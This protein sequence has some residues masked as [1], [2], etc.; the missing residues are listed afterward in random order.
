MY[1]V[2]VKFVD[3]LLAPDQKRWSLE[4]RLEFLEMAK[5]DLTFHP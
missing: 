4:V 3:R 1:C 5:D 2:A